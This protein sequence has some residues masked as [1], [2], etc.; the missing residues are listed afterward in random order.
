MS[1]ASVC[2]EPGAGDSG[3]ERPDV[4]VLD[5]RPVVTVSTGL[6]VREVLGRAL[7]EDDQEPAGPVLGA[8]AGPGEG[9]VVQVGQPGQVGQVLAGQRLVRPRK[10]SAVRSRSA[11]TLS[12]SQ[13][14]DRDYPHCEPG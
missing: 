2:R 10:D 1:L 11:T 5:P 8:A 9:G 12:L 3:V 4:E 6:T 14:R 13:A 7:G